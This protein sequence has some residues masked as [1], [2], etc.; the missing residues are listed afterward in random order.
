MNL[1]QNIG[2][3]TPDS[4]IK[5]MAKSPLFIAAVILFCL[6]IVLNLV[7]IFT[8][9]FARDLYSF[10]DF[11][12]FEDSF[13]KAVSENNA[14]PFNFSYIGFWQI[15][16][17]LITVVPGVVMALAV[18]KLYQEVNEANFKNVRTMMS[19]NQ[20]IC[21]VSLVVF[22]LCL[23]MALGNITSGSLSD[24]PAEVGRI[25]TVVAIALLVIYIVALFFCNSVKR[26]IDIAIGNVSDKAVTCDITLFAPI[27]IAVFGVIT[28]L[29]PLFTG[30]I[31]LILSSLCGGASH[32]LFGY[33]IFDF[34]K[35]MLAYAT[36]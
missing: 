19:V 5:N 34:R 25:F 8:G 2:G 31:V 28:A 32:I 10:A 21:C 1:S 18:F 7:N 15:F 16:G 17:T 29:V 3:G 26:A 13:H 6:T 30:N 22:E 20:I 14:G 35:R 9:S 33:I 24:A 12:G 11:F 23:L 4:T 27:V 36:Y